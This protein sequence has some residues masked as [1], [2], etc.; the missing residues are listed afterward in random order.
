MTTV[1]KGETV[2]FTPQVIGYGY[3][4][5]ADRGIPAVVVEPVVFP[6]RRVHIRFSPKG[7]DVVLHRWVSAHNLEPR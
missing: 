4:Y 7:S 6:A 1:S 3:F 2:L 5:G